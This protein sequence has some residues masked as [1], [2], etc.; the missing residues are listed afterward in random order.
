VGR[1]R[2]HLDADYPEADEDLLLFCRAASRLG[3]KRGALV[4]E[5]VHRFLRSCEKEITQEQEATAAQRR[6]FRREQP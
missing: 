5:L 6:A 4:K 1:A 2:V 3:M